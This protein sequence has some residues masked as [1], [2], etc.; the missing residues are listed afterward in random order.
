M[1][2]IAEEELGISK[3]IARQWFR[4]HRAFTA[5]VFDKDEKEVLRVPVYIYNTFIRASLTEKL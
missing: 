3:I 1:G 4:T 5:H 2:F